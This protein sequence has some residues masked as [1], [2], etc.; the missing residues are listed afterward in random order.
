MEDLLM[1]IVYMAI[2]ALITWAIGFIQDSP[3]YKMSKKKLKQ[4]SDA[5]EDDKISKD[6]FKQFIDFESKKVKKDKVAKKEIE[7]KIKK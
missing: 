6:E 2:P 5:F 7:L 3:K 4:L 1:K